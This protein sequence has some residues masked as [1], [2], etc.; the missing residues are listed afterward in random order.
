M[1]K[2]YQ[3]PSKHAPFSFERF[4]QYILN[5]FGTLDAVSIAVSIE[6]KLYLIQKNFQNNERKVNISLSQYQVLE[7]IRL[8][9]K[10]AILIQ[11][12]LV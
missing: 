10:K 11:I 6:D 4:L 12:N 5:K 2:V 9:M 7:S 8:S 1:S 3:S